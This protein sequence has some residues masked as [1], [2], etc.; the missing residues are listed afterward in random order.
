MICD[1]GPVFTW[2][3]IDFC[4][5]THL[6]RLGEL[7]IPCYFTAT[8]KNSQVPYYSFW[9][10]CSTSKWQTSPVCVLFIPVHLSSGLVASVFWVDTILSFWPWVR[11]NGQALECRGLDILQHTHLKDVVVGKSLNLYSCVC[12]SHFVNL[13]VA[14]DCYPCYSP[15]LPFGFMGT[16]FLCVWL[17][18]ASVLSQSSLSRNH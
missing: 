4:S 13:S 2:Y 16:L 12:V 8:K 17:Q 11:V 7:Q 3:Q 6:I 10:V 15:G 14:D 1:T 18:S 5:I 9:G